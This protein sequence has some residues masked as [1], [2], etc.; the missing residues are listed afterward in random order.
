MLEVLLALTAALLFALGTVLQQAE[1]ARAPD[2]GAF[3]FRFLLAL[4]RRPRWLAGIGA[5]AGG[6]VAQAAALGVGRLVVVQPLIAATVVFALPLGHRLTGQRVT[7]RQ[8]AAAVAVAAG[9]GAFLVLADPRGGRDD[10]TSAAWI[11]AFAAAAAICVPLVLAA[12]RARPA[13]KATFLGIATGILWGL[14]AGLTKAVVEDLDDGVLSVLADWHAYALVVV[15]YASMSLS[16]AS[17]QAGRL[18][19]AVATQSVFDPLASVLLGVVAF[20]EGLHDT[21]AE[22]LGAVG[23]LAVMIAGLVVLAG[24]GDQSSGAASRSPATSAAKRS[25][26]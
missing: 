16:Q 2:E 26:V 10:A 5:D 12:R 22:L 4:A 21:P 24:A 14:A 9:L 18:A 23:G 19:P 11:A 1:A 6:F 15:G 8:V 20:R 7:R 25:R 3:S 17:L 13:L